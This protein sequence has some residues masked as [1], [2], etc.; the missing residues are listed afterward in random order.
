ME[1]HAPEHPISTWRDF[2]I[3]MGT[4]TLGL[5]IALGLEQAAE[6]AHHRHQLHIAEQNLQAE[7]EANRTLLAQDEVQ[8]D[9]SGKQLLNI[10]GAIDL[11]RKHGK[12]TSMKALWAWS[13]LESAA[14]DTARNTGATAFMSYSQAQEL[15][16]RYHQQDLVNSQAAA[17]IRSIYPVMIPLASGKT[18]DQL[19]PAQLDRM[20][21]NTESALADLAHLQALCRGLDQQ[22]K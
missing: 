16:D 14:W 10:L 8:L 21:L 19:T 22:Y 7:L 9:E 13:D 18:P 2:L 4:I 6:W 17:Y 12:T 1:V 11:L 5:L 15:A 20:E 3:H